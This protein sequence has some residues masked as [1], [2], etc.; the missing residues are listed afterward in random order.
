MLFE[1]NEIY[2]NEYEG[3]YSVSEERFITEKEAEEGN[4]RE[5]KRLK[6]KNYFRMSK[7]QSKLIDHI[8]N[9]PDFIKPNQEKMKS[10]VF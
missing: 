10:L 3:L 4:F 6:E 1:K 8:Q 7:Y 5:I 9:N 2:Q